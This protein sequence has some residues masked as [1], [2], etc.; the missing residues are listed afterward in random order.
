MPEPTAIEHG[1]T[2]PERKASSQRGR[3][4]RLIE[5]LAGIAVPMPDDRP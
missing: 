5:A 1:S 4:I 3:Q 2:V